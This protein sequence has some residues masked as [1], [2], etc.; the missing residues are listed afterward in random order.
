MSKKPIWTYSIDIKLFERLAKADVKYFYKDYKMTGVDSAEYYTVFVCS[1]KKKIETK[2]TI[3]FD[4][5]EPVTSP[6]CNQVIKLNY[7]GERAK[8]L[9]DR[10][11]KWE[12]D[13]AKK[14]KQYEKLKEELGV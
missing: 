9:L 12:K 14:I 10:I 6:F 3:I 2:A 4:Y 7:A 8:E 13:H 11:R 1:N 5:F